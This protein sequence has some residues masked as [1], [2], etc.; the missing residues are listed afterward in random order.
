MEGGV[1]VEIVDRI[2]R[3][4]FFAI[5]GAR[6]ERRERRAACVA[7]RGRSDRIRAPA[8]SPASGGGRQSAPAR[9][10]ARRAARRRSGCRP[11]CAW[12]RAV[13]GASALRPRRA[14]R[15]RQRAR[16]CRPDR[17]RRSRGRWVH[18]LAFRV[19]QIDR[20]RKL[21][22]GLEQT[23]RLGQ[24]QALAAHR[25]GDVDN[26]GVDAF[27]IWTGGHRRP[28][29]PPGAHRR[30][31]GRAKAGRGVALFMAPIIGRPGAAAKQQDAALRDA[32]RRAAP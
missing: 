22:A 5:A 19:H 4:V 26:H 11:R 18:H 30:N 15:C 7:G 29:I 1:A 13:A 2:D 27:D 24:R 20:A 25:A 28:R 23:R 3:I 10:P 31:S 9:A 16:R 32:R 6:T 21:H 8:R 17:R 12:S 14:T